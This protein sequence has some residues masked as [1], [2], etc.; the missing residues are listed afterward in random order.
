[1]VPEAHPKQDQKKVTI[2]CEKCLSEGPPGTP[3]SSPN[4]PPDP[5]GGLLGVT[6]GPQ[7]SPKAPNGE[8]GRPSDPP[9]PLKSPKT[10]TKKPFKIYEKCNINRPKSNLK[11]TPEPVGTNIQVHLRFQIQ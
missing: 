1:M 10:D 5:L 6:L 9:N 2:F 4:P 3:K 8:P 7:G 11:F